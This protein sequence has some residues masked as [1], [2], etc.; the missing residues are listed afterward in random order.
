MFE[1]WWNKI[2]NAAVRN[3]DPTLKAGIIFIMGFVAICCLLYA[4]YGKAYDKDNKE[5]RKND[6]IKRPFFFVLFIVLTILTIVY[7]SLQ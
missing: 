6:F 2:Y 5:V 7:A 4:I 1:A 3:I